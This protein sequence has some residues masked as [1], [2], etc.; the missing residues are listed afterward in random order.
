MEVFE[1]AIGIDLGTTYSCVAVMQG[2]R[3]EVISND[4]GNRT[5]PS[6]VAFAD[7]RLIGD[8]AKNQVSMNPKNTVFDAKRLIG[9][10]F[11][12]HHVQSDMKHWPFTVVN[13]N[14][15]PHIQV[16]HNDKDVIFRPEEISAMVLT[17][18]KDV[19]ES[20]LGKKV[21]KAVV[22]VPAYFNNEQREKTKDAC[23]IAGMEPLRIINE[24]TAAA[25]AYGI[26]KDFK[27]ERN[28]L[29]FDL[30]GGTFDVSLLS[31]EDGVFEVKS[32]AGNTHL[33]G[34]DFDNRL[35]EYVRNEFKKKHKKDFGEN[36]RALRRIRTAC[37][38]AKRN[39]SSAAKTSIQVDSLI[40]GID[41]QME[42]TRAKFEQVNDDLFRLCLESV[43]KV[44]QDSG[45]SKDQV[46]DVVL[47]GGSSRI[48]K[49]QDLLSNFFNGK[50]L[51]KNINPD[52]CV[53][54]GAAVQ[55][56]N[57]TGN[58]KTNMVLLDVCPL[59]LG[60]QTGENIF[61]AIIDRNSAIP[62]RKSQT[63]TTASNNQETVSICIYEGERKFTEDNNLL[64]KFNLS[65]I[66]PAPRG[67]PKIEVTFNL[68]V[69]GILN[70]S[71]KDTASNKEQSITIK[72]DKT[73]SQSDIDEMIRK[74]EEMKAQ[75]EEK[76]SVVQSKNN[77][78]SYVYQVKNSLDDDKLSSKLSPQDKSS[79]EIA[80]KNAQEWLDNNNESTKEVYEQ[81]QKD[82]ESLV[83]PI[84][85]KLYSKSSASQQ[86]SNTDQAP[87]SSSGPT[88]EDLEV[89]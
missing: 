15:A 55:A 14:G 76:L 75:D 24:P 23:L 16:K 20:Y 10:S 37:E 85:T 62:C 30:G 6:Y 34:E 17:K 47:V 44:L 61:T 35:V 56:A 78:E 31:I 36:P 60:L 19:A 53:A 86:S 27:T 63:F 83:N 54:Y 38:S 70:V 71:A 81:K 39:L 41:F 58:N 65:G 89:D 33:G 28:V 25:I 21:T 11:D 87:S 2:G 46:H 3:V 49:V 1:G 82:L 51:C 18:M 26:D 43:T 7:E 57:L 74:A 50:A 80:L 5:T 59:S 42:I 77:L 29:I 9:R 8:A 52:E 12:D 4:Q 48:P 72:N 73:R 66:A 69:N 88:F 79:L 45:F 40:D 84:M 67:V 68:D 64:G 13:K 22:T 32:T